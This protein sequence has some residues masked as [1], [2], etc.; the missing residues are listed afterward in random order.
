M[1]TVTFSTLISALQRY[2]LTFSNFYA[3]PNP[4]TPVNVEI[5]GQTIEIER[6]FAYLSGVLPPLLSFVGVIIGLKLISRL[7]KRF[8]R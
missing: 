1:D 7:V 8:S 3:Y 4:A 5:L 2:L 6:F